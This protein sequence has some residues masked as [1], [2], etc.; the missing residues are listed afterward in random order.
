MN[1]FGID[2]SEKQK[3]FSFKVAYAEGVRF[4]ILAADSAFARHYE[5]AKVHRIGIGAYYYG[6]ALTTEA[7]EKEAEA[8]LTVLDGRSLNYPV[9]YKV[10]NQ[11]P[12]SAV[13]KAFCDRIERAGYVAGICAAGILPEALNGYEKWTVKWSTFQP[14]DS[15]GMWQFG[16]EKNYIRSNRIA[17]TVCGQNY[18]FK[19]YPALCEAKRQN[20][21][22]EPVT[23]APE[24]AIEPIPDQKS[25]D[26]IIFGKSE[27]VRKTNKEIAQEVIDGLWG[28]GDE[29]KKRLREAGYNPSSITKIVKKLVS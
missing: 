13:I 3:N 17:N 11:M 19:N 28:E 16:K 6:S 8:L 4:V 25:I 27:P 24:P 18:C 23:A 2:I 21:R 26:E 29:R 20:V 7:A 1:R 12:D 14:H 10:G 15:C 22:V 5:Q 9:Y